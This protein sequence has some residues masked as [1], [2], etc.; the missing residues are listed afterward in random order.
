MVRKGEKEM[1]HYLVFVADKVSEF[2]QLTLEEAKQQM[3][4][5][6]GHDK[7]CEPYFTNVLFKLFK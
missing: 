3:S 5:W 7:R 6:E 1:L 4:Q 2:A